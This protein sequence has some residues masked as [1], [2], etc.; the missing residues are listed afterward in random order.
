MFENN[1]EDWKVKDSSTKYLNYIYAFEDDIY[2][3][4]EIP[5]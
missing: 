5:W 4:D 3:E 1:E 2:G